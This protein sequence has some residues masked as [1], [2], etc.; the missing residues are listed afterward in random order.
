MGWGLKLLY[1]RVVCCRFVTPPNVAQ[2]ITGQ[3][4]WRY[5]NAG[6][7]SVRVFECCH[8]AFIRTN[9]T[10][11][12]GTPAGYQM[13]VLDLEQPIVCF[14]SFKKP[15]NLF[16]SL[17]PTSSSSS[18]SHIVITGAKGGLQQGAAAPNRIEIYDF[19]KSDMQFSLFIQAL[20]ESHFAFLTSPAEINRF[21][22]S[23][24]FP[25]P[26]GQSYLILWYCGYPRL[27][28]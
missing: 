7:N 16:P 9:L 8:C 19:V 27:S 1:G 10:D 3:P 24:P 13:Q 28:L 6:N 18:M 26:T 12:Q 23:C 15:L 4:S 11:H 25:D 21:E 22:N 20:S 5:C 17:S 2:V 14:P